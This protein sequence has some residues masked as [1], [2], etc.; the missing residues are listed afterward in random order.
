M[1]KYIML[2]TLGPDGSH[3][4]RENPRRLKE[5]NADV[6]AMGVKVLAQYALLGPYDFV[7]ILEAPN[8][9]A[10]AR[11]ATALAARGTLKTLTLT[12]IDVDEFIAA[13]EDGK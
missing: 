7:N 4:L 10:V 5:V 6:E 2:S 8:E 9:L 11:V 13:L 3:T 12:A 1:P